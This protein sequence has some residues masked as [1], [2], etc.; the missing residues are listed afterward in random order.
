MKSYSERNTSIFPP[1][2]KPFKKKKEYI[3]ING[4]VIKS[5]LDTGNSAHTS[6]GKKK[7]PKQIA[8]QNQRRKKE[9][10]DLISPIQTQ[11]EPLSYSPAVTRG[12]KHLPLSSR[13]RPIESPKRPF[14]LPLIEK[15]HLSLQGTERSH[16]QPIRSSTGDKLLRHPSSST[17]SAA[18]AASTA[19]P[20]LLTQTN[21]LNSLTLEI[22]IATDEVITK[23]EKRQWREF[24]TLTEDH[25]DYDEEGRGGDSSPAHLSDLVRLNSIGKGSSASVYKSVLFPSLQVVADK[26]VVLSNKA[27]S[28]QIISE[29]KSLK[30]A[31][32]SDDSRDSTSSSDPS[33]APSAASLGPSG[34]V[35]IPC[36]CECIVKLLEVY[37]NPRDGTI[38]MCLEYMNGG[39]LQEVV[40]AGGCQN[41]DVLAGIAAMI[42]TGIAH[43]HSRRQLH[44]DIK[45]GNILLSS[46]LSAESPQPPQPPQGEQAEG[47][48]Q[49]EGQ[50]YWQGRVKISDFGLSKELEKGHSLADSFLGTFHYMSP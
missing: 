2:P 9:T 47:Q 16:E 45:P 30:T 21:S 38:S 28:S 37:P 15:K 18:A 48:G 24:K 36:G 14:S 25:R 19:T 1:E 4:T 32:Q 5:T 23:K 31:L 6:T 10:S 12:V 35:S 33:V 42:L 40:R 3:S 11:Q 44:R 39:S 13:P 8:N 17:S 43:L 26:V 50:R 27:K 41:E 46:I 34:G 49:G 29:L 22:D 7:K 20:S